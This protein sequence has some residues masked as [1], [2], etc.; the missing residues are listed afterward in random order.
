[1]AKTK[2]VIAVFDL[3]YP[4]INA[5]T[6]AIILEFIRDNKVDGFVFGGDQF[7][8]SAISHHNK[9][10]LLY[11]VPGQFNRDT[12]GFRRHILEPLEKALGPKAWRIWIEGNHDH[13]ERQLIEENPELDG[14]TDRRQALNLDA[15][16]WQFVE[17]GK[18]FNFGKLTFIHGETLGGGA[19]HA[20][21]AVDTYCRNLLYGH[22][23]SH[24]TA[25]KITANKDK[26]SATCAPIAGDVNPHYLR[27][28]PTAWQNGFVVIE[29]R[30]DGNFNLYPLIV[31]NGQVSYAG[32]VY[33]RK[34]ARKRAA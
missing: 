25:T 26:W 19:N 33:G 3:H 28:R 9:L 13:W 21:K 20:K 17:C 12:E 1:M 31:S 7:D 23:H 8:N 6:W 24:Q 2:L 10:K 4:T 5:E 16:G 30:P 27:N 14:L 29:F 18:S 15:R 34:R 22:F 11:R 32:K